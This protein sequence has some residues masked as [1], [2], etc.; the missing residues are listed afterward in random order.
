MVTNNQNILLQGDFKKP[1]IVIKI[2]AA[3][4]IS[5]HTCFVLTLHFERPGRVAFP[6]NGSSW[7]KYGHQ[8]TGN[9]YFTTDPVL[10][11]MLCLTSVTCK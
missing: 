7:H 11:N 1:R 8:P 4:K 6:E 2:S 3:I 9:H 10:L 5:Y